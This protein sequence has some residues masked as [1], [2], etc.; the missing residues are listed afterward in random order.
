MFGVGVVALACTLAIWSTNGFHLDFGLKNLYVRRRSSGDSIPMGSVLSYVKGN[1]GS[2]LQPYTFAAGLARGSM[3]LIAISIFAGVVGFSV[4]GSKTSAMIPFFLLMLLP[5]ITKYRNWFGI[6]V[7][8]LAALSVFSVLALWQKTNA[9]GLPVVT[10]WRLFDVKGLL[11][12]YYWEY[13]STHPKM[14]LSDGILRAFF[15]N[16]Y[17]YA[18]PEQI[19]YVYFGSAQTNSNANVWASSF[20]DFGFAGMIVVTIVLSQIFR[21]IDSMAL[22]RGF[23][24]PAFL[25]SFLGM[26]LSDVA[27]DTSILSHGTLAIIV[28]IY[29]LPP[30]RK[31]R[32]ATSVPLEPAGAPA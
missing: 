15:D 28:L 8:G 17:Q 16:P 20:G 2:A 30:L 4:D 21:L 1:L 19:G 13:F 27:L 31:S 14:Y 10:T 29:F 25:S 9:V 18:A 23:L 5:L 6:V 3:L 11:S 24:I 7:P 12:G 26:K 22:N 32:E